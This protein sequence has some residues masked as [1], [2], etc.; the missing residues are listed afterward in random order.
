MTKETWL[1][2]FRETAETYRETEAISYLL[3][4][5]RGY[6]L[7]WKDK[8]S[9][10]VRIKS[11]VSGWHEIYIGFMGASGFRLKLSH[12][13]GFRWVQ[14]SV[15]WNMNQYRGEEAFYKIADLT[16]RDFELLP[17]FT[18]AS[19]Y[20]QRESQVAYLR[21][22]PISK[23]EAEKRIAAIRNRP[24]R[25]AGAVIDGH[26]VLGA[27][28]PQ[29]ADEIRATIEP[30][31]DSDFKRIYWGCTISTMRMAF[32]SRTGYY[33]GQNQ[34]ISELKTES[35]RRCASALQKADRDGYDPLE[36]LIAYAEE[37]SLEL[38]PSFRIQQ[39][40]PVDY[41]G[42]I[43]IDFNSPFTEKHPEWRHV[44][45]NG[46]VCS[47]LFSHF[48]PGWEKYKLD[49][50]AEIA[51]KG[52]AGI[53]L[54]LM[55][56]TDAIWDF[57]PHAVEEFKKLYGIDPRLGETPPQEW[58]QFRCDHLT[59]FMRKLRKQTNAIAASM[60]K[61]IPIAVQVSAERTILLGKEFG[62]RAVS[63]NFIHGY[64]IKTWAEEGLVDI[65]APSFRRS[66]TPMFC[67]HIY[68]ELGESREKIELAPSLGQHHNALF[69]RGYDWS[70]YFTDRG[71]NRENLTPFG[72]L[73]GWRI[74]REANDLYH[75]G[76]D[77]VDVWEMGNAHVRLARW[78]ILKNIGDREML[79][80]EFGKRIGSLMGESEHKVSFSPAEES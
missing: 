44:D 23:E 76:V 71:E 56:E 3:E 43:G 36:L 16:D 7:H 21:L 72:E 18:V 70:I 75:Q 25:T 67:D 47:Y 27:Y 30:F 41:S 64:D 74:L 38:W 12:E 37:N 58:Y 40:Y 35:N 54:N 53:H 28:S 14:S 31:I 62:A 65:I 59:K 51:R 2:D 48:H 52:P 57:E 8:N 60:G 17:E 50:L 32:V 80:R 6:M 42:G 19:R 49:I 78:S 61:H 10:I 5:K 20:D 13:P 46:E 77:A 26:E 55:C 24:T 9:S 63:A 29:S 33:L 15:S 1:L 22:V 39:D 66:Y 68:D 79:E 45:R 4:G 73:D 69:P 34:D 11:P